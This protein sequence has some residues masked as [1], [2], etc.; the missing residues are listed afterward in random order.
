MTLI[1]NSGGV[2]KGRID[3]ASQ[4]QYSCLL[5]RNEDYLRDGGNRD[6]IIGELFTRGVPTIQIGNI[7]GL[8]K[9][10]GRHHFTMSIRYID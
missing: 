1:G 10:E 6:S 2:S 3:T 4:R 9:N 7:G 5:T 8:S